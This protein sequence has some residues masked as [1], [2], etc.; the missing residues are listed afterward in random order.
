MK[1]PS[2][3]YRAARQGLSAIAITGLLLSSF[4]FMLPAQ[5]ASA[6][7]PAL[8]APTSPGSSCEW[9]GEAHHDYTRVTHQESSSQIVDRTSA[10]GLN[11]SSN[12]VSGADCG[13]KWSREV[14]H[15]I[16]TKTNAACTADPSDK[17]SETNI[18]NANGNGSGSYFYFLGEAFTSPGNFLPVLGM[19]GS[20]D[21]TSTVTQT[22]TNDL[23]GTNSNFSANNTLTPD[24]EF[25]V[26]SCANYQ[27][28]TGVEV[29]LSGFYSAPGAQATVGHCQVHTYS[30]SATFNSDFVANWSWR[31]KKVNCDT[32]V[33]TDGG[34]TG[35]CQEYEDGTDPMDSADDIVPDTTKPTVTLNA[36]LNGGSVV[37]GTVVTASYSCQDEAGGSGLASCVSS[38]ANGSTLDTSTFGIKTFTIT[39]TDNAGNS[40]VKTATYTVTYKS[41]GFLGPIDTNMVNKAKAGSMIPVQFRLLDGSNNPITTSSSFVSVTS[42]VAVCGTGLPVDD[43]EQY[44]TSPSGLQYL[45]D[46]LWQY[47]WKTEKSY[48]GQCRTMYLNL[49]DGSKASAKFQF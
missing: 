4:A 30:N 22:V 10:E 11:L 48:A 37:Q 12:P 26:Y 45:G 32:T 8:P 6:A 36:P 41:S 49:A 27:D 23:C 20:S 35:D 16:V 43:I 21:T 44:S 14:S 3:A 2:A 7:L 47:N 38:V 13:M 39:A 46:G 29:T 17:N 25:P 5:K 31:F 40:L 28:G 42:V 1:I 9:M 33:N 15:N 18:V 24:A 34:A 19:E